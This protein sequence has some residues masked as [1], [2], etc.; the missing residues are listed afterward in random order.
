[1]STI[2][3][4]SAP[5][6]L[7]GPRGI[8]PGGHDPAADPGPAGNVAAPELEDREAKE[9]RQATLYGFQYTGKGSFIDEV[10]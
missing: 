3:P 5:A 9:A 10:F 4:L 8:G 7:T 6:G 2:D 1:M